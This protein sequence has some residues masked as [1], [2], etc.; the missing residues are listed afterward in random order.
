MDRYRA[1]LSDW[2]AC[3]AGGIPERAP[4]AMLAAGDGL[5]DRIVVAGAA[6]HVLDFDD[7][8]EAG[9]A[10]VSAACAPAAL[11]VADRLGASLGAMLD[12]Y[13]A[14]FEA[15]AAVAAA[16]HPALYDAGWHPTAVCG[17]V[18]A[19]AAKESHQ[20]SASKDRAIRRTP[21]YLKAGR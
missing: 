21:G 17:P 8:F 2:L 19:A 12:A 14:G 6:G 7:T 4:R 16:S 18:G 13:A 9:I 10:H 5:L 20:K 3:A 15:M 1:S 11:V